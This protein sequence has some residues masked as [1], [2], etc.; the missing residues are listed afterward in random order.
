MKIRAGLIFS[1][2]LTSA[3]TL[4]TALQ[5]RAFQ[6]SGGSNSDNLTQM[7]LGDGRQIL[8]NHMFV[9][10]DVYFHSGYYP[11]IFDRRDASTNT[12]PLASEESSPH[13][14]H[15][16]TDQEGAK[17]A[18][19]NEEEHEKSMRSPGQPLDWIERFGRKFAIT[20]HTHLA[21]GKERE[22]LPWLRLSTEL[23]PH[24]VETYTVAS[25]WLRQSLGKAKEAEQF[26]REGLAANPSSYEIL[27]ELGR[28]YDENYHDSIRAGNV[29]TVAMRRW[30][31]T[32]AGKPE[33]NVGA[34]GQIVVRLARLEEKEG[35]LDRAIDL[36]KIA[37][38]RDATP[39]PQALREQIEALRVRLKEK[40]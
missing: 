2:L 22:M 37:I 35:H 3:F 31:E 20:Q 18:P 10:A 25:Y 5:P 21:N 11:S 27:L 6:W 28:L 16:P 19:S 40:K 26:L 17:A 23:D 15:H 38:S 24:R 29:W 36:L 32:E 12:E 33:P 39:H 30:M 8:A 1:F 13:A 14:A 7:L 34:L 4:A 9:Q